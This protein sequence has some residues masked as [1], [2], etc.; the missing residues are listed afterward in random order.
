MKEHDVN[1]RKFLS[2]CKKDNM[3]LNHDKSIFLQLPFASLG[4][5]F[6]IMKSDHIQLFLNH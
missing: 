5:K 2:A 6:Q 1:L 4:T 3:K